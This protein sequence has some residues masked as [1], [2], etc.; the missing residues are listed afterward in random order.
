[1]HHES[2]ETKQINSMSNSVTTNP[3][4]TKMFKSWL[5]VQ[6]FQ[7]YSVQQKIWTDFNLPF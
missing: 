7:K 3:C 6:I 2:W 4:M 1:M 5:M